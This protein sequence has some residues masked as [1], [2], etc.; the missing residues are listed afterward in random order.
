MNYRNV[1]TID[2]AIFTAHCFLALFLISTGGVNWA[3]VILLLVLCV[4]T[5]QIVQA[6]R[7]T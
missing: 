7:D 6:L 5:Y 4:R 3:T 1:E 2:I